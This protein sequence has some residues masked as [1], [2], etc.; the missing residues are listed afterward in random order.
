MFCSASATRLA[1]GVFFS[2]LPMVGKSIAKA[3][4]KAAHQ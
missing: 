1:E 4:K 2:E 3:A